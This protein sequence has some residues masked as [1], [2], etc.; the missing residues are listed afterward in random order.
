MHEVHYSLQQKIIGKPTPEESEQLRRLG[1]YDRGWNGSFTQVSELATLVAESG[2]AWSTS[3]FRKSERLSSKFVQ[4]DMFAL[5]FDN[6]DK[7]GKLP[8]DKLVHP[9]DLFIDNPLADGICL[10]YHSSSSTSEWPRFR[11][12][13]KV[14]TPYRDR[15]SYKAF[16]H[17]L[18]AVHN[19]LYKGLDGCMD[20][21]RIWYGS[22]K[23]IHYIN[24]QALVDLEKLEYE[25]NSLPEPDRQFYE[26]KS[27]KD[28][29]PREVLIAKGLIKAKDQYVGDVETESK[30]FKLCLGFIP[31]WQ[32]EGWYEEGSWIFGAAVHTL[33]V[34]LA[35]EVLEN[36]WGESTLR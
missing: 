24:E 12:V 1:A 14:A 17:R 28:V 31:E 20:E 21:A 11:V 22:T 10:I 25:W 7:D 3:I 5:D 27:L 33:G 18:H 35:A 23:G 4:A 6:K 15:K 26:F 13:F 36:V 29:V 34:E 2:Y 19:N 9:D 8:D 30:I 16:T 32:S